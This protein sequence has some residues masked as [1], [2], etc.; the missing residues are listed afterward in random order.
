M[1]HMDNNGDLTV[2]CPVSGKPYVRT[3]PLGMFCNAERCE[4]E[5]RAGDADETLK[6]MLNEMFPGRFSK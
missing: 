6:T 5:E 3:G 1:I 4:C 2:L